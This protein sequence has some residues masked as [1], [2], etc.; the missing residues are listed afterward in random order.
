MAEQHPAFSC[1]LFRL[2][3]LTSPDMEEVIDA[4]HWV[5]ASAASCVV[6]TAVMVLPRSPQCRCEALLLFVWTALG[7]LVPAVILLPAHTGHGP[8]PL[9]ERCLAVLK[10]PPASHPQ[11]PDKK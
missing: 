11:R 2:Q 1:L 4:M 10:L 9:P 3:M 5:A 8:R 7:W 6:P